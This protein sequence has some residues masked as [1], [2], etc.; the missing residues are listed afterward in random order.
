MS[1]EVNELDLYYEDEAPSVL[2]DMSGASSDEALVTCVNKLG[3][4]DIPAMS[5]ST[6]KTAEQL[7]LDLR[8]SAIFQNPDEFSEKDSWNI[9]EGWL[10]RSQYCSGNLSAKLKAATEKNEKFTGCFADNVIALKKMLPEALSIEKIHVSLGATWV[11]T[12]VYAEFARHLLN[13]R[14]TPTII[15][16]KQ[17]N[18][19]K[20]VPP[21]EARSSVANNITYGTADLS[22]LKILEQTMNAKTVKVYDYVLGYSWNYERVFN[23]TATLAAQE[24]QKAIIREFEKWIRQSKR[25]S[26]L[27]EDSYNETFSGYGV[28]AYD[29]EFLEL[30]DL[31]PEVKLY[32]HQKNAI[33]RMLLSKENLLLAHDVGTGKTYEMC[34]GVHELYRMGLSRKNMV[35]VPNNVL[36]ATVDSHKYLYPNDKILAIY[37]KDF[38]PEARAEIME[39]IRDEDCVAVYMAYSSFDMIKM[40]NDYR[41]DKKIAEIKALDDEIKCTYFKVEKKMLEKRKKSL[42]SECSKLVSEGVDT[43]WLPFDKLGIETLVVDEAHNYKN[44]P[45]KT[46]VDNIVG[47]HTAGSKKCDEMLEKT[48]VV[49]KLVMA[50]GTPLTNS[51]ADLFV[52]QTYLQPEELRFRE[53]DTFDMWLN[54]FAER[55]TNYEI[56][57]DSKNLRVMTRFSSFHNLTELMAMFSTVCDFHYS[58]S[59]MLDMP[60]FNGYSDI[61]V[62]RSKAQAEYILSLAERTEL[63]RLRKVKRTEDN[64]LKVTTDG[65]KCALDLRLLGDKY[66][67]LDSEENKIEV[68][69]KKVYE[70]YLKHPDTCQVVFSD[71]GTPKDGFNVYDSLKLTLAS[72]GIPPHQ[73]AYVHDATT[74]SA[75]TRLFAAINSGDIRVIIGSTAKLGVGVNVQERLIALHHLSVPW[76]PSDMVQREGRIVRQGNTCKEVFIYRYITEGSFDAY[77]WQLLENKQRFISSFLS[78]T[79]AE[80]DADDVADIVLSYAEVKA[81]AIGNPLIKKRV[82]TANR[83]ERARISCRQRQ[84]QLIDLRAVMESAPARLQSLEKDLEITR[85]DIELY[86]RSKQS[87][88]HDERTAFGEELLGAIKDNLMH[89]EERRFDEYQG[90]WVC[91]P[92]NMDTEKPYIY[93]RSTNGGIYYLEMDTEKPLGCAMRIDHLLEHLTD[94]ATSIEEQIRRTEMQRTQA[95]ADFEKGNDYESEVEKLEAELDDIDRQLKGEEAKIA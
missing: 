11:P 45:L 75:R 49:K 73:I 44:I 16:N 39:R 56:D 3:R 48:R 8:G 85:L 62:K 29:G 9:D 13:L 64:L 92:A 41:I 40:S 82:E 27:L 7:V 2:G 10:L 95:L 20:I 59:S 78:G 93:L 17:I 33:A 14:C 57:V 68:C 1:F 37:P 22:A 31:N 30:P 67:L 5:Q 25:I 47:M 38:T 61:R 86:N 76:R 65:G 36:K 58:K 91:L 19:W 43:P 80:R 63:I 79:S 28:S 88:P 54:T 51:L 71:I 87:I 18:A 15:R 69:A 4:V 34:V 42:E 52:L 72:F 12:K 83:L 77:S 50:T 81:L 32:A 6:G 84:K 74:E 26:A 70:I 23:R 35:V 94:R 24:K 89:T 53:I 46:K 21:E 90:F 60:L 66:V 55:E